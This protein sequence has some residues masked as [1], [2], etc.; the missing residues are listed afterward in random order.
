MWGYRSTNERIK[1]GVRATTKRRY[2]CKPR[3]VKAHGIHSQPVSHRG[4]IGSVDQGP[5]SCLH[6]H[7]WIPS[8][9]V[10]LGALGC[11]QAINHLVGMYIYGRSAH[12]SVLDTQSQRNVV[13]L[14]ICPLGMTN[15]L[16]SSTC[17]AVAHV[18]TYSSVTSHIFSRNSKH[19]RYQ[20][21]QHFQELIFGH[22]V[23]FINQLPCIHTRSMSPCSH[24]SRCAPRTPSP[25]EP[26]PR[27][28][29]QSATQARHAV[30][31]QARWES[32]MGVQCSCAR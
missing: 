25:Y 14:Y 24:A 23:V 13:K 32:Q 2:P 28:H 3:Q 10:P 4:E 8:G 30:V 27:L 19:I 29:I 21:N 18:H 7:R 20:H 16:Q 11:P 26:A 9:Q 1:T 31:I 15:L 17:R 22:C 6:L 5:V 12:A